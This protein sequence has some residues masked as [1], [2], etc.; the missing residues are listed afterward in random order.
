MMKTKSERP[1]DRTSA[2]IKQ[3]S[4]T[5]DLRAL[6]QHTERQLNVIQRRMRRRLQAEYAR[7]NLTGPQRLVMSVLVRTQGLSLRQLSES[8]SLA[9]STVS[10]IAD[11]LEKQGMLERQT[12]ATDRRVTVLVASQAVREFLT[13]RMPELSLHPLL[14][15]L[16]RAS[17]DER[18]VI[19]TGLDTLV[20]LL[21]EQEK[22]ES[23]RSD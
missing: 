16:S 11:R 21:S 17:A 2:R 20:R 7:G 18:N 6:A 22:W 13:T 19:T 4:R 9:H 3:D 1:R 8:V 14:E 5:T 15:A 23:S 12:H 10:G